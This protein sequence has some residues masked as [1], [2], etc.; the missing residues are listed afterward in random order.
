M[1][2]SESDIINF[3]YQDRSNLLNR[4]PV[5]VARHFQYRVEVFFKEIVN[6]GPLGKTKFFAIR[7]EFQISGSPHIDFLH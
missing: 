3:S 4:N 2:F 6:D 7:V 5:L 1:N